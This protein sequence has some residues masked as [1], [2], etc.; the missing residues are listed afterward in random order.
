MI[1]DISAGPLSS[2]RSEQHLKQQERQFQQ[3]RESSVACSKPPPPTF[4]M[5]QEFHNQGRGPACVGPM[6]HN[7]SNSGASPP[8]RFSSV[9]RRNW[10]ARKLSERCSAKV[11][12]VRPSQGLPRH[13]SADR[14]QPRPTLGKADLGMPSCLQSRIVFRCSNSAVLVPRRVV[15]EPRHSSA[16]SL[17]HDMTTSPHAPCSQMILQSP[18]RHLPLRGSAVWL[19]LT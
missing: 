9:E 15:I 18:R 1:A 10:L 8:A 7:H 12:S 11:S 6:P 2:F 3:C 13:E 4:S 17:P 5:P 14:K 19:D 16:L